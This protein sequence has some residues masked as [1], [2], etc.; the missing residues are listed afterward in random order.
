[1]TP[2]LGTKTPSAPVRDKSGGDGRAARSLLSCALWRGMGRLWCGMGGMGRPEPL[3]AQRPHQQQRL[4]VFYE[5][6]DPRPE[7]RHLTRRAAQASA[8]SEVFTKHES[9]HLC[10]P[11][12]DLFPTISR[13]ISQPPHPPGKGSARRSVAAFLHVVA[14]HG[15][16][17][18]RHGL[19]PSPAPATRP[20]GFSPATRHATWFFPVPPA[21]P[22]RATP[23]PA[24]GFFTNHESRITAFML[25]SLL[26]CALWR[27]MGRLWRGMGGILSP[28]PRPRAV[29]CENPAM[30]TE[31]RFPRK[32]REVQRS[33]LLPS[34]SGLNLLR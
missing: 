16:A 8:N 5:T 9:L 24:N 10:F 6:R 26:S 11:T 4:S 31:S 22:R 20:V 12:H 17:M 7:S 28:S 23:T 15:A 32:I 29:R 33:P 3:S 19:P 1:M 21:T 25:F 13:Q 30:C 18:E 14:Q 34:P 27:G 2:L